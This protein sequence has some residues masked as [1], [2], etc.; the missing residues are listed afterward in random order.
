MKCE[1]YA[2]LKQVSGHTVLFVSSAGTIPD[3]LA[4][5]LVA[6]IESRMALRAPSIVNAAAYLQED[7]GFM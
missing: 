1:K 7:E 6:L 5:A 4:A 3:P 2:R